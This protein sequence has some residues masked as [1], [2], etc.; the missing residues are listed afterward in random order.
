M[1]KNGSSPQSTLFGQH[2]QVS[3]WRSTLQ[4]RALQSETGP[5]GLLHPL[6]GHVA[7]DLPGQLHET[8][9]IVQALQRP[10]KVVGG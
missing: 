3:P 9:V 6:A 10:Q 1:Q 2:N 8:G 5:K 7:V 4:P